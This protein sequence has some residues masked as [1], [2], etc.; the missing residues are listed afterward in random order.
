MTKRTQLADRTRLAARTRLALVLCVAVAPAGCRSGVPGFGRFAKKS[1]PSA[2]LL[3]G[4]GPTATYPVPPSHTATPS[5]I[6]SI[7][8]GTGTPVPETVGPAARTFGN[9]GGSA[10]VNARPS[11]GYGDA[12]LAAASGEQSPKIR[13]ASAVTSP[14]NPYGG[15]NPYGSLPPSGPSTPPMDAAVANGYAAIPPA[16]PAAPTKSA[17]SAPVQPAAPSGGGFTFPGEAVAAAPAPAASGGGFTF[18]GATPPAAPASQPP[19]TG[20]LAMPSGKMPSGQ[21][22]SGATTGSFSDLSVEPAAATMP[23]TEVATAPRPLGGGKSRPAAASHYMPGSTG[24]ATSYPGA[25][26]RR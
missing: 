11:S 17:E 5:P 19:A 13:T 10:V 25:A 16:K 4:S 2:E 21:M 8:A 14:T 23:A 3:A 20:S 18:P 7:V 15:E 22:P 26:V 6:D 9:P 24:A 1:E 12:Q